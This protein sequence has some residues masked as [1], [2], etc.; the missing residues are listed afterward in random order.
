VLN[1]HKLAWYIVRRLLICIAVLVATSFLVFSLQYLAPGNMVLTFL[2][3]QPND[4]ATRAALIKEYHLNKPFI[5]QYWLWLLGAVHLH[6]GNSIQTSQPVIDEIR[7]RFPTSLMLG[8][9]GYVLTMIF[10]VGLGIVAALRRERITD[11]ALVGGS[12]LG[13]STPAFVSGLLLIYLFGVLTHVFPVFGQGSGF[14]DELW[15]LTLPAI[16][17][18][19]GGVAFILKHTRAA[20]SKVLDQDYVVFARARGLSEWRVLIMYE[21]RNALIPVITISGVLLAFLIVGAVIVEETFSIQGLGELLTSSATTKDLP[22]LQ[23]V[24]MVVATMIVLA[25]LLADLVYM[26]VD[27]RMRL[28]RTSA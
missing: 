24:T 12:I 13:L 4:S 21:L 3:P 19:V 2:G 5:D 23:G 28:G 25:N 8:L 10:G 18:A 1:R 7:Q 11:R 22:M 6:F 15:H 16:T 17:L 27:P 14:F 26:A 9:Y 20:V